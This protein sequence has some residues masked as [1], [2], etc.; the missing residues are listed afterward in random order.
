[1]NI[2]RLDNDPVVAAQMMCDKHV[3]KMVTEY[4]QLLST[5][6]RVLMGTPE[7]R[8]SKSG[9]RMVDHYVVRGAAKERLLYK[10][11]HKNHPSAIWARENNENYRWLY[12]HFQA[13][14]KEYEHRY[15]RVHK[16]YKD[17][18]SMLWFSPIVP[19]GTDYRWARETEMPQCMPD[20]CKQD[21]VVDAYRKYY[22]EEKKG[23][24]KWTKRKT[25]NW[26]HKEDVG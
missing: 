4:G 18:G 21:D 23:F 6:H 11:A 26:F 8:L 5:A 1:M 17:L 15:G 3:C 9:K 7:K 24:A 22:I 2:F 16:T 20:H 19:D 14:A 10:V 12:K 13:T 25:P